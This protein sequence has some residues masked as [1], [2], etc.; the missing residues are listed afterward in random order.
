MVIE[1]SSSGTG[2]DSAWSS[3]PRAD[4]VVVA[5]LLHFNGDASHEDEEHFD[6]G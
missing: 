2:A 4:S 6:V 1:L 3:S 5:P